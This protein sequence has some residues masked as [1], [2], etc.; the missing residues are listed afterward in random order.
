MCSVEVGGREE[1]TEFYQ[2]TLMILVLENQNFLYP[3][4]FPL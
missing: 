3:Y 1:F 4:A 2:K